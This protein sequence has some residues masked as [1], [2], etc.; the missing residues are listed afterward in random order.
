MN[1]KPTLLFLMLFMAGVNLKAQEMRLEPGTNIRIETGTTLDISDGNLV[2]ES[3]ATGDASLLDYGNVTYSGSGQAN[4]QRYITESQWHVISSPVT[5]AVSG[6][7]LNDFL[8]HHTEISNLWS[9]ISATT[10]PLNTMQGFAL[11]SVEPGPTSEV[12]TG[13]T[14]TGLQ[15][16]AFTKDGEGWNLLGNPY[17]SAIDWDEV[18]IPAELGGA[19]WLWD[20]T[21]GTIGDYVFYITGGGIANTTS[22]FI[23]SGQGFFVKAVTGGGTLSLDNYVRTHSTQSFYKSSGTEPILILKASGNNITSQT[24]IRFIEAATTGVDRL[25][26]VHKIFSESPDVPNLFTKS[27]GEDLVINT[28]PSITGNE[29]VPLW[30]NAGLPG[31]YT[32]FVAELETIDP[33]VPVYLEDMETGIIQDLRQH[34]SYT[35]DHNPLKDREFI[36]WFTEIIGIDDLEANNTIT[37]YAAGNDLHINFTNDFAQKQGFDAHIM[38]YDLSGKLI[39]QSQ[40]RQMQNV[41][42]LPASSSFYIVKVVAGEATINRKILIN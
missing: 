14:H 34:P 5:S 25:Y 4:V 38:V 23:P 9:Y 1:L 36:V 32:I 30:F 40:T 33:S 10:L 39:A 42:T 17:P 35:F 12:F 22:Q 16:K 2:L 37:I 18:T 15:N 28:L 26:D 7:F 24:A 13:I 29:S 41:L 19:F 3:D 31:N 21:I 20:P 27:A 6:M 11:W 8:Q